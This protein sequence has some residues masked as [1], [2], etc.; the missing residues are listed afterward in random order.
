MT[1]VSK[2]GREK[3]IKPNGGHDAPEQ[4]RL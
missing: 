4:G 3:Q 2:L 1:E